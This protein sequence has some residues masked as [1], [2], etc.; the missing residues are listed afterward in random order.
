MQNKVGRAAP[1][2]TNI[3]FAIGTNSMDPRRY[4]NKWKQHPHMR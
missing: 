4:S 2:C 1:V 3:F